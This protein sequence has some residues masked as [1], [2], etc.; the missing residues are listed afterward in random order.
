[1]FQFGLFSTHLP[2]IFTVVA[3]LLSY[4]FYTF[5]KSDVEAAKPQEATISVVASR[6]TLPQRILAYDA[7]HHFTV[8]QQAAEPIRYDAPTYGSTLRHNVH[9]PPNYS[10]A[11][12]VVAYALYSRP[13]TFG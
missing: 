5:G 2:Y 8:Q 7:T 12:R 10:I 3:Y 4:G 6:V 11:T 13:P 9:C 1:M